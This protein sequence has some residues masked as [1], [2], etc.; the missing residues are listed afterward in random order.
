VL[1]VQRTAQAAEDPVF[2]LLPECF[3]ALQWHSDTYELP[4]GAV[5]LARSDAYE[6][7]AFVVGRAYAMQFHLEVGT[8]LAARWAEVPAYS[9]SLERLMGEGGLPRLLAQVSEH[10]E[11]MSSLARRLF[12]AWLEHVVGLEAPLART[13][14]R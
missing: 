8:A 3:A 2:S 5:A 4:A 7:Q 9:E 1:P 6:Q 14:R 12:A 11:A 13:E 10:E